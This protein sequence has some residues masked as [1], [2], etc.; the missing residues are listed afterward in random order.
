ML[1]SCATPQARFSSGISLGHT[2]NKM[3]MD[4]DVRN[5]LCATLIEIMDVLLYDCS[6]TFAEDLK[7]MRILC[8]IAATSTQELAIALEHVD[9]KQ[10]E[11]C[12]FSFVPKE[13]VWSLLLV[14][15]WQTR[16]DQ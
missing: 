12:G 15:K 16:K 5:A 2:S 9:N 8:R 4:I 7:T 14:K 1:L 6:P 3:S 11:P 10:Q 13:P